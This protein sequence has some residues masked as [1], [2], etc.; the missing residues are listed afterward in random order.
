MELKWSECQSS[1][2]I[3]HDFGQFDKISEYL[4]CVVYMFEHG[5]DKEKLEN[6]PLSLTVLFDK[7]RYHVIDCGTVLP[8]ARKCIRALERAPRHRN[9]FMSDFLFFINT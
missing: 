9:S 1:G 2:N 3:L 5:W 4:K 6:L 7:N 8:D